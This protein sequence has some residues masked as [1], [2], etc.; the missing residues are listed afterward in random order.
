LDCKKTWDLIGEGNT[1]GVFQLE[2]RLGQISAKDLRPENMEHMAALGAIL[3]PGC[4]AVKRDGKS[5]TQHYIDRKNGKEE[6][7]YYHEALEPILSTTYGEMIYQE[8]AM[9][10]A[11][12]L[13][14]FDL[15]QADVLRKAIGKKKAD[16]MAKVK[17]E[18]IDGCFEMGT[19]DEEEASAIFEG[20]EQSQRYAFNKSH[21]VAYAVNG[22]ISAYIKAHFKESFFASWLFYAKDKQKPFDEIRL[23]VNT[24]KSMGV[25]ILPPDFRKDNNYFKRYKKDVYFGLCNIKNIGESSVVKMRQAIFY[26]ETISD[27]KREDWTWLEFLFLFSQSKGVSSSVVLGLIESGALSYLGKDR[28][29]MIYEY[30][31]YSELTA[32]EQAWFQKRDNTLEYTSEDG[33]L[34]DILMVGM[35]MGIKYS[36]SD[37]KTKK[38][39]N[40]GPC[41]NKNRLKKLEGLVTLLNDPPR[42][43]ADTPQWISS[44]EEAKLGL[45]LTACLVDGC[46]NAF[47]AN[48]TCEQFNKHKEGSSGIFIAAQIDEIKTHIIQNGRSTGEEMAFIEFSDGDASVNGVIF[49][50][51]W[52]EIKIT[53]VCTPENTVMLSG[54]RG[55]ER[56]SFIVKKITQLS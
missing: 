50:N 10:I 24:A 28:N 37:I 34:Q 53:G 30:N 9:Q 42:S 17:T 52:K 13:A 3:R 18:F 20:I 46:K 38:L 25:N 6:I 48:C 33:R 35:V 55:R 39:L 19:V 26:A 45:P 56:D 29:Q 54:E 44:I 41:A 16:V 11:Q 47:H 12:E 8:Q 27:K 51:E 49:C 31:I 43:L 23:L 14:G 1:K 15:Q 32:K 5:V 22:Y 7:E 21:S 40:K 4:L 2:T 36:E